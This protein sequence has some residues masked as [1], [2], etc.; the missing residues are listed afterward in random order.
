MYPG[1]QPWVKIGIAADVNARIAQI[2]RSCGISDL[3]QVDDRE[4][5]SHPWYYKVEELA[6]SELANFKQELRCEKCETVHREWFAVPENVALQTVQRWRRFIRM[7]PY[8]ENGLLKDQW[9][10]ML[11]LANMMMPGKEEEPDDHELRNERWNR[12]LDEG[13]KSSRPLK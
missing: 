11:V 1:Q 4:D 8:D 13:F 12:W 3:E 6:H 2:K 9:S 7:D 5:V 10:K